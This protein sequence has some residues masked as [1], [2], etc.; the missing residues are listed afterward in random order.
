MTI[1]GKLFGGRRNEKPDFSILLTNEKF[2]KFINEIEDISLG[3]SEL[4]FFKFDN[5]EKEQIGYSFGEN[6]KSFIGNKN[7]D[8]KKSWFVIG[9]DG[10]GDPIFI[11][12]DRPNLPVFT[13]EHGEGSWEESYIAISLENFSEIIKDL[14]KLSIKR[15][16]P[17][18]IGKNPIS[19]DEINAFL[20]K[21]H[22]EN[23]Y[24]DV[25]Y[26]KLFLEND[27]E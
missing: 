6:G 9:T 26:W 27:D 16:N 8:W 15:E 22:I 4:N 14:K 5:I 10:L 19:K 3:Y 23:K 13:S 24:M 18:A 2:K 17:V 1:F 20:T 25:W 12:F 21:T 7:G 11:D